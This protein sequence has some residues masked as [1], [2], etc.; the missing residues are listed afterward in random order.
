MEEG[1]HAIS[2]DG[3]TE[4]RVETVGK[5]AKRRWGKTKQ[6]KVILFLPESKENEQSRERITTDC[7]V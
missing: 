1:T 3:L 5:R 2:R 7:G 4:R 6:N